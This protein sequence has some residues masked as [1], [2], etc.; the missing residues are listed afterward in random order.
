[1]KFAFFD[2]GTRTIWMYKLTPV[3]TASTLARASFRISLW[4]HDCLVVV[5]GLIPRQRS[6]CGCRVV[7]RGS[8]TDFSGTAPGRSICGNGLCT[9]GSAEGFATPRSARDLNGFRTFVQQAQQ[10]RLFSPVPGTWSVQR[11]DRL[12]GAPAESRPQRISI[13][14]QPAAPLNHCTWFKS[15]A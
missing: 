13:R 9:K 3:T 2:A 8:S 7:W 12:S 11:L 14:E 15:W 4:H 6:C 1:M 10:Q 5:I